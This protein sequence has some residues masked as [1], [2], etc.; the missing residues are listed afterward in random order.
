[1]S[2]KNQPSHPLFRFRTTTGKPLTEV[3]TRIEALAI[4][5][6]RAGVSAHSV[7]TGAEVLLQLAMEG[8]T[9]ELVIPPE[10]VPACPRTPKPSRCAEMEADR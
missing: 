6:L 1:M 10:S 7:Q 9:V 3:I 4:D 2:A 8:V 5:R